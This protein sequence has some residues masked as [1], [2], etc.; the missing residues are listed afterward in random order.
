MDGDHISFTFTCPHCGPTSVIV[1]DEADANSA[2]RCQKCD[3]RFEQTWGQVNEEA[4][5]QAKD[6]V[7]DALKTA[8]RGPGWKVD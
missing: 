8:L 1:D 4:M 2:V 3:G 6:A 7:R 5:R